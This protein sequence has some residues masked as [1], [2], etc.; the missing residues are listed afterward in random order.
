MSSQS[1]VVNTGEYWGI[2][3][4]FYT[5][6]TT[7]ALTPP[8]VDL[9]QQLDSM[10]PFSAKD[11]SVLDDGAGSGNTVISL[12]KQYPQVPILATD[13]SEGMMKELK[14]KLTQNLDWAPVET[15]VSNAEDLTQANLVSCNF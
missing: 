13:L 2:H 3:A 7:D 15:R 4:K 14:D 12:R 1:G 8:G 6:S 10:L 9:L 5:S 11:T